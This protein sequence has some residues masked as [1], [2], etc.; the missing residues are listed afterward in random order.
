[1]HS[2]HPEAANMADD[3]SEVPMLRTYAE[4]VTPE[5]SRERKA[6]GDRNWEGRTLR[7]VLD[8]TDGKYECVLD[9]FPDRFL[10]DLRRHIE[11]QD[12]PLARQAVETGSVVISLDHFRGLDPSTRVVLGLS[13][14]VAAHS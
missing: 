12:D 3:R 1:M 6:G 4:V 9:N 5:M 10:A 14:G 2:R 7:E 8:E 11:E 13:L